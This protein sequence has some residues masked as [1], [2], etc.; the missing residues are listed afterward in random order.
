MNSREAARRAEAAEREADCHAAGSA[1]EAAADREAKYWRE[2][3]AELPE[4]GEGVAKT[5]GKRDGADVT[6]STGR[7][8]GSWGFEGGRVWAEADRGEGAEMMAV[9]FET[10]EEAEA[11]IRTAAKDER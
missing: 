5:S 1:N 3:A 7:W 6:D 8:I 2:K 4:E 9:T 10:P 11:A